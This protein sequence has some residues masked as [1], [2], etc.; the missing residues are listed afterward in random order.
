MWVLA[1]IP[2]WPCL[3]HDAVYFSA[4]TLVPCKAGTTSQ[5]MSCI[6]GRPSYR[7]SL[8]LTLTA[9]ELGSW[10]REIMLGRKSKILPTRD[11]KVYCFQTPEGWLESR[12]W[13]IRGIL[14][15]AQHTRIPETVRSYLWSTL[16]S[17]RF[18]R[19]TSTNLLNG[20]ATKVI[21]N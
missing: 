7:R 13:F 16:P 21:A 2:Y 10:V 20:H 14:P 6:Q 15:V 8:D 19:G 11:P 12:V 9:N 18:V 3:T 4:V 17:I 1:N 5:V